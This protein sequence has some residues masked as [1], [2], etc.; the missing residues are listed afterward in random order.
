MKGRLH[1]GTAMAA[2]YTAFAI[3][4]LGFVAFAMGRPAPL[5]SP[6]YYSR[7]LAHDQRLEAAANAR[8]LGPALDM[9]LAEHA[10]AIHLRLPPAHVSSAEGL[11]TL[12][13]PSD[14]TADRTMPLALDAEGHQR[15]SMD[16]MARG[17]WRLQVEW[18]VGGRAYYREWP[19]DV[20]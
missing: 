7:G 18:T 5:V 1:W 6:E 4:T 17:R 11:V 20:R 10:S 15:I 2:A 13:R 8:A 12:Y 14:A 3:A 16:G 19:I 9:A